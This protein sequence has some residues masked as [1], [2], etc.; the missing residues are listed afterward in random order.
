MSDEPASP[1]GLA[2]HEGPHRSAHGNRAGRRARVAGVAGVAAGAVSAAVVSWQAAD[3]LG[4]DVAAALFL[5]GV[6]HRIGRLDAAA[7]QA[8]ATGEDPTVA[9][10]DLL[11]VTAA[12]ACIAGSG[13]ALVKAAHLSGV[14]KASVVALAISSVVLAWATVHTVFTL[15]YA[16][17]YYTSAPGGIDF[18]DR[19]DASP[20]FRDF[21]YVAFTIG[22][23]FQ[24]SDTAITR[25]VVRLTAL[26]HA[27]LSYLF[28]AVIVGLTINVVA[29]LLR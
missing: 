18:N 2:G 27:L 21:A 15:R 6:W 1:A 26:W 5:G 23:T 22:M 17:L 14:A 11:V 7:T 16:R 19:Q 8:V 12:I 4:W 25:P 9:L 29:S 20:S 13:L 10:A 3:L 28:G 24:V